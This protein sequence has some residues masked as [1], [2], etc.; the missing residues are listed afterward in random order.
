MEYVWKL[1]HRRIGPL[2]V[3]GEQ[4]R[5]KSLMGRFGGGWNWELGF[6]LGSTTLIVN[7]LV[8][9]FRFSWDPKR[10]QY[11]GGWRCK[12]IPWREK[13]F[14]RPESQEIPSTESGEFDGS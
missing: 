1:Q 11:T 3:S 2:V 13:P 6:Q 10:A 14:L 12:R 7:L 9:M 8:C 5:R 4:R